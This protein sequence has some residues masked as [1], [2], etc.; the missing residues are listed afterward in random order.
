MLQSHNRVVSGVCV[1]SAL[2]GCFLF[3]SDL[4]ERFQFG[5]VLLELALL[6]PLALWLLRRRARLGH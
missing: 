1:L 5:R 2:V 3:L 6:V 4:D